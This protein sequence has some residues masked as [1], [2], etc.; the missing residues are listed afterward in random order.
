MGRTETVPVK[1]VDHPLITHKMSIL[2]DR[3]TSVKKFRDLVSEITLLL[4]YE[5]T[6]D[7]EM[8]DVTIQTPLCEAVVPKL[9]HDKF[10]VVPILRAGAGMLDGMLS[11]FPLARVTHVGLE[12]DEE[13][14]QPRTYYSKIPDDLSGWTVV[15]VD[16]MLATAGSLCAALDLVKRSNP[17]RIKAMCLIASPEGRDRVEGEH[18]DVDIYV[19]AMDDHL[20]EKAYIVP[21]LGDAG[22]RIYG[23]LQ[24]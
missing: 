16:P 13:T 6:R 4:T 23:T 10:V 8:R 20:N 2:R 11:I 19:G 21:G 14:A 15:V 22:D 24:E 17:D 18:P 7:L 12:R 1:V 3:D 5:A 9:A